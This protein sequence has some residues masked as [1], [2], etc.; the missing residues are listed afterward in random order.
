MKYYINEGSGDYAVSDMILTKDLPT[1]AGSKMLDGFVS[2]FEAEAVTR[3]AA[4]GLKVAGKTN[5]GEFGLDVIGETSYFGEVTAD[6]GTLRGAAAELVKDGK[7][8]F[9]LSVDLNGAP[10]R[11]AAMSGVT[12]IKPS[13]GIVS[14]YGTVPC[15]CSS[16]TIGV[17]AT[18]AKA[19]EVLSIIAGNDPK[20]GTTLPAEKY[21]FNLN[22]II[23]GRKFAVIKEYM[24][25]SDEGQREKVRLL[26]ELLRSKGAEV[27]EISFPEAKAVAAAWRI[28]LAAETCNNVSRY[29]GVK[30]GYRTPD[31]KDIDELYTKSRSEA[32][33]LLTK[34]VILYGSDV[35]SKGRYDECYDKALKIRRLARNSAD[36]LFAEYAALLYPACTKS[37]YTK[38]E[39]GDSIDAASDE[40]MLS[41]LVCLLGLPCAVASGVQIAADTLSENLLL[42]IA[43]AAEEA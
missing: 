24:D 13:Y 32:F 15:A 20:D 17:T 23:E 10:R 11:A 41:S 35:L 33:G 31:Y 14:R 29:D 6:D 9:A 36:R 25:A 43:A 38:A 30:F 12:Y 40:A 3:L 2:L 4:A 7:V 21:D 5:V 37:S 34:A 19:A 42:A 28:A 22:G 26:A 18:A 39:L 16:E 1:T 8:P 27:T